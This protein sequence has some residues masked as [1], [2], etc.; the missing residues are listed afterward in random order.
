[1]PR[2]ACRLVVDA[3]HQA[4]VASDRPRLVIDQ[5]VAELRVQVTLGHRHAD[6]HRQ[7]LTQRA[8]RRLDAGKLEILRVAR[9]GAAHLPEAG[10]VGHRRPVIAGEVEQR[11]DQHR[12]V[13]GRQDETIPVRPFRCLRII[14]QIAR[15]QHRRGIRHPHRH[16]RMPAICRLDGVHRQST[17]GVGK[18]LGGDRHGGRGRSCS[19]C[20]HRLF[21]PRRDGGSIVAREPDR[22]PHRWIGSARIGTRRCCRFPQPC[23]ARAN[24]R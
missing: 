1:V 4:A 7:P 5:I 14:L 2:Q 21:R 11:V 13:P 23:Y 20:R 24:V 6:R 12:T 18:L 22:Q 17:D 9:A 16:P 15:E 8:G 19:G 10:K 3:F